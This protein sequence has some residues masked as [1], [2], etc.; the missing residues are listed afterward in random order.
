MSRKK[1]GINWSK[2]APVKSR[3]VRVIDLL[4]KQLK[5]GTKTSKENNEKISLTDKDKSRINKEIET[6]N[7]R[8]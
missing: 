3:R 6:L 4:E 5:N 8:I 1:S 2:S 7:K